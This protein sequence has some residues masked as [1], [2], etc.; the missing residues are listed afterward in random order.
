[1]RDLKN[2]LLLC[3]C[4]SVLAGAWMISD[5]EKSVVAFGNGETHNTAAIANIL[6][7]MTSSVSNMNQRKAQQEK[8]ILDAV[9]AAEYLGI[10]EQILA[11][12]LDSKDI[13]ALQINSTYRFSK[14]ALDEWVYEQSIKRTTYQ[15]W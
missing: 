7:N 15:K 11:K 2:I 3:L 14:R 4:V 13:P 12:L 1:M 5:V 10:T 6:A 8:Q 9:E